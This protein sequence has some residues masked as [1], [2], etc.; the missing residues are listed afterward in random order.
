VTDLEQRAL[1]HARDAFNDARDQLEYFGATEDFTR[2]PLEAAITAYIERI[3]FTGLMDVAQRILD[4]HYPAE[5]FNRENPYVGD[6]PGT[7]L[8]VALRECMEAMSRA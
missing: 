3:S 1:E 8:V 5:F 4:A 2:S 7:K 6:D